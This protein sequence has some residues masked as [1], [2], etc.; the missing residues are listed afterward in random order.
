ML[1][2]RGMEQQKRGDDVK[3]SRPTNA[4][5]FFFRSNKVDTTG[6]VHIDNIDKEP[7]RGRFSISIV[8]RLF[9]VPRANLI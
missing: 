5:H 1:R 3:R 7:P 9:I 6:Y 2:E 8:K 4:V